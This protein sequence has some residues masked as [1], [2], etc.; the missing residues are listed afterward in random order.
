L[1]TLDQFRGDCL[2][3][4]G[5]A[6]VKTPNLDAL[7]AE[8]VRLSRHYSQAAPCSPGRASLYTGMYQMNHRVLGNGSPLDRSFDNVAL[9]ARRAGYSPA[10]FGYTDQTVDPR[11]TTRRDDPRLFTYEGVLPGFDAVLDLTGDHRAWTRWLA[12]KGHD[13]S[14][15][16]V[17]L[18]STENERP[19]EYSVS[20]FL[21]NSFTSWLE[22]QSDGWFAHLSYLRPHP[23]Y[24]AAGEFAKMYDPDD[25]EMP[26]PRA[27]ERHPLHDLMLAIDDTAAPADEVRIRRMRA[28][29]YGMIS[30]VDHQLGRVWAML[31]ARG[32]WNSTV[33]VVTSDHAELL[34]DHGL[35]NKGGFFEASQHIVGIVHDP[36]RRAHG[37]VVESFTEN[38]DVFP[39]LCELLEIEIPLQCDGRSLAAFLDDAAPVEWRD[40]AHWE[41]DWSPVVLPLGEYPWPHDRRLSTYSLAVRR[42]VTHAYVQFGDGTHL[43][44]D[45]AN[46]PSWRTFETNT[47][48]VLAKAQAMLRWRMNHARRDLS[49]IVIDGESV[50]RWP[51][52]V[53]WRE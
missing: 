5:H 1:I 4:A 41:Y 29:Y 49:H 19:V 18:L 10:L 2:S 9:M 36:R 13:V 44:F 27:D 47:A 48:V 51:S 53:P 35:R 30:E 50:G 24:R 17:K 8:G 39:T 3:A 20:S 16:H 11:D 45:I 23:P 12:T 42:D 40:A 6:L 7:A 31:R 32:E 37:T 21:T 26:I 52:G 34:G 25:V 22:E 33:I 28:Q 14:S 38:V 43:C 15:G 46:D